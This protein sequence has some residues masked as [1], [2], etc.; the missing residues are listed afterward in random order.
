M[1]YNQNVQ[2][3]TKLR[4]VLARNGIIFVSQIGSYPKE[5][6]LK[7]RCLGEGSYKELEG[8]YKKYGIKIPTLESLEKDLLLVSF[9]PSQLLALYKNNIRSAKDIEDF[10]M[11]ELRSVYRYDKRLYN[12]IC[13]VITVKKLKMK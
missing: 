11:E 7:I 13:K 9:Q 10:S 2:I 5:A 3:F 6:Y 12:R 8:I 4:N 1:D